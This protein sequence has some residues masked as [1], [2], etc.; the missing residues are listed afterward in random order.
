[1]IISLF[2]EQGI[3]MLELAWT[4]LGEERQPGQDIQANVDGTLMRWD[5]VDFYLLGIQALVELVK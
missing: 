3:D 5:W 2:D 1:L 4:K